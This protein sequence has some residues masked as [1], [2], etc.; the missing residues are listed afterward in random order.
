MTVE[1]PKK[2]I[3][4]CLEKRGHPC[5]CGAYDYN[6]AVDDFMKVIEGQSSHEIVGMGAMKVLDCIELQ[7]QLI[8]LD[9]KEIEKALWS[10]YPDL[11]GLIN[12]IS[13]FLCSTFGIPPQPNE[14]T[15][16]KIKSW[17]K[18]DHWVELNINQLAQ[19]IF[20]RIK[21]KK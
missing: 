6:D 3:C 18:E 20:E 13:K 8:P 5:I 9:R 10:R 12:P 1:W 4:D 15:V 2:K 14:V 11:Q 16:E 17:L 19:A 7:P 21:E